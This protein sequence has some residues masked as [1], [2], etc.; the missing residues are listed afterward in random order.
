RLVL[1][2]RS[3]EPRPRPFARAP[4]RST[5]TNRPIGDGALLGALARQE[6]PSGMPPEGRATKARSTP[7]EAGPEGAT[8]PRALRWLVRGL[9]LLGALV[10]V[11][12]LALWALLEN[13]NHPAVKQR[14]LALVKDQA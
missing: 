9:V 2:L 5:A 3:V 6:Y 4:L 1:E 14:L 12:A 8:R 13:L 7:P 10:V 11:L